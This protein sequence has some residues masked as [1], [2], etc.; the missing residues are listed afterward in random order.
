[1]EVV[2]DTTQDG[3][4]SGTATFSNVLVSTLDETGQSQPKYT[5]PVT[6]VA[7]YDPEVR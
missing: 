2:N 6:L 5:L 7:E 3:S 4:G 1:M